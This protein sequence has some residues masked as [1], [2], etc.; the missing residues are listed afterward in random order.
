MKLIFTVLA[1]LALGGC[2]R[3]DQVSADARQ[4]VAKGRYSGVG[5]FDAGRLWGK[6]IV[7]QG[8][9][10][11]VA[12]RLTD[13]EHII[14]VVD[15]QTGE[16]RQCGDHTGYCVSISPWNAANASAPVLPAKLSVHDEDDRKVDGPVA[17]DSVEK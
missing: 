12:A 11:E 13:D 17:S 9:N 5:V 16:V 6:M 14:V 4:S 15:S 7:P 1:C 2:E 8:K 10:D 3:A